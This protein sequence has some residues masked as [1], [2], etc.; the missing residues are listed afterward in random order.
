M[1]KPW[2]ETQIN[3]AVLMKGAADDADLPMK[4]KAFSPLVYCSNEG[5]SYMHG[6]AKT[7]R[8]QGR[9]STIRRT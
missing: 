4:D 5:V 9:A 3:T 1:R 2:A 6:T 8:L 7:M